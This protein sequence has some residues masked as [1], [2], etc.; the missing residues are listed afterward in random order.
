[1][2]QE[3]APPP[4]KRRTL[5]TFPCV[6]CHKVFTRSDHLARHN[7]NHEPKQVFRCSLVISKGDETKVCGKSF[8][9]KDLM[10]RHMKRH[11]MEGQ[12]ERQQ[13]GED[14]TSNSSFDVK[15]E[16]A[17]PPPV[18]PP[19]PA[20]VPVPVPQQPIQSIQQIQ[21]QFQSAQVTPVPMPMIPPVDPTFPQNQPIDYSMLAQ[22]FVPQS[23]NDI[24]SW[25]FTDSPPS[26]LETNNGKVPINI[27]ISSPY[28]QFSPTN[29]VP[30]HSTSN[31]F[32]F[33]NQM[34]GLQDV[35]IFLNDDNP[36]D[37]V[38]LRNYQAMTANNNNNNLP[39][40]PFTMTTASSTSPA[41]ATESNASPSQCPE[42][43]SHDQFELKLVHHAERCNFP[44][45]R[46]HY[47]DT[48]LLESIFR[49]LHLT[50]DE[51]AALFPE[52]V[53]YTLEDRLSYYL[54]MYWTVFHKQFTIL[55]KPSFDTKSAHPL[56]LAAMILVG[57][58]YAS[59]T[60]AEQ[61]AIVHRK[62]PEFK[63]TLK[64]AIPLRFMIFQDEGF[65][66]PV[67]L[68]VLQSLNMLEWIEKNFLN[69]RMH[70]RGHVHHGTTVQ[71]LRR[72]PALGGNPG[73]SKRSNNNSG[74]NSA[75][76]ESDG[77]NGVDEETEGEQDTSDYDLFVKWV[78][79]ESMKR[80]TFMTFYLDVV[81]YIKFRHNPV[82]SVHQ[83]QFLNLPCD[84]EMLWESKDVNGS[85][86][87]VVKR[88]KKISSERQKDGKANGNA[89]P[90]SSSQ[91]FLSMLKKFLKPTKLN[92]QDIPSRL[93]IFTRKILLAGLISVMQQMQQADD[94][95][96]VSLISTTASNS[97]SSVA[98]SASKRKI[99]KEIL[100]R[101]FDNYNFEIM[102]V[103]SANQRLNNLSIFSDIQT[104]E[105]P[106]PIYHLTQ[107]IGL[108]DINHYDIAIFGGSPANQSVSATTNDHYIVSRKLYSM[109][110]TKSRAIS[111]IINVRSVVHCYLLLWQLMLKPVE[112]GNNMVGNEFLDWKPNCDY[113]DCMYAVS[114]ATLVLWC[115]CFS[116]CGLE[117]DRFKEIGDEGLCDKKYE[118]LVQMSAED[119]YQYL[120]RVK[121][122][123][124]TNLRKYNLHKE[125]NLHPPSSSDKQTY[126]PNEV[127]AK[128]C[129]LLPQ[130]SNKQNISGVCFLVGT[131]LM[132][133]QWEIIR[134]NA[135][136]IL[137]CGY[138]SIGKKSVLCSDLFDNEFT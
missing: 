84:D 11:E 120:S 118:E 82:I 115:Y 37:E 35:N 58:S 25:L 123:F 12:L 79:S 110:H 15:A 83:L 132:T 125:F 133:S 34:Y 46:N 51:I 23:Q 69:R 55:H 106:L 131:K 119:G 107:I 60:T 100:V 75:G 33:T 94:Q 48:L 3:S 127:M 42:N 124:L 61:L 6:H 87:K 13:A 31:N 14:T 105:V 38:F 113:Y 136:L 103:Y 85:F 98:P 134:E 10:E 29:Q 102:N 40:N 104:P 27:P 96:T 56:L 108:P 30:I 97:T 78:E 92:S 41:T 101:A 111:D 68:W 47:L 36:L 17:V 64:C 99:W 16:V 52:P 135:K 116:T 65:Q 77:N 8:V 70:E 21:P 19:A 74:N 81:D 4:K 39:H 71:L 117:S 129:D 9:R 76:E 63:F 90:K 2:K 53:G 128:Y 91:N 126:S 7:L 45:N 62:S 112:I 26:A 130:I 86:R 72:S 73:V 22:P 32:D 93:S 114:V 43:Y 138:R 44:K 54:S 66:S 5:G 50:R 137:N 49:S 67:K 80:V 28:N 24:L 109:W 18:P 95:N 122:E 57:A 89:K 1:M 20:P 59:P 88:Q 121:Q